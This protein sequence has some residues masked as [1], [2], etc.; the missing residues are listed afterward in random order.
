MT[1]LILRKS[2]IFH[3]N[4]DGPARITHDIPHGVQEIGEV[5]LTGRGIPPEPGI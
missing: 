1:T 2:P 3:A 4:S 5:F